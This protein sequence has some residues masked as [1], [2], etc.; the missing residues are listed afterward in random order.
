MSTIHNQQI[1][2]LEHFSPALKHVLDTMTLNGN[3]VYGVDSLIL[4]I[5]THG[6]CRESLVLERLGVTPERFTEVL[7]EIRTEE[8][9][10]PIHRTVR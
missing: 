1:I 10:R 9:K 7:S 3:G 8:S 5:L 4:S 2:I 6:S